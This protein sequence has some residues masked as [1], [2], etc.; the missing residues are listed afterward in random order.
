MASD[1]VLA[2]AI[3]RR[4]IDSGARGFSTEI[5]D[6]G[7]KKTALSAAK[8]ALATDPK[9][10]VKR[11]A[12][13]RA[14]KDLALSQKN[15][16]VRA[17]PFMPRNREGIRQIVQT[18]IQEGVHSAETG[19]AYLTLEDSWFKQIKEMGVGTKTTLDEGSGV[20]EVFSFTNKERPLVQWEG[21]ISD[22][23]QA[24]TGEFID[25]HIRIDQ[26]IFHD[27]E[28]FLVSVLADQ[29]FIQT[30]PETIPAAVLGVNNIDLST[31][32]N[33]DRATSTWK[34]KAKPDTKWVRVASGE[35]P[36]VENT[37]ISLRSA[38][39]PLIPLG[40]NMAGGPSDEIP[41]KITEAT[42]NY[43]LSRPKKERLNMM[44][45]ID[46]PNNIDHVPLSGAPAG[47]EGEYKLEF[48]DNGDIFISGNKSTPAPGGIGRNISPIERR[49]LKAYFN[50][51]LEEYK[52][53]LGV[54]ELNEAQRR[55]LHAEFAYIQRALGREILIGQQR[56]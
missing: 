21:D 33:Y 38:L 2:K 23:L 4:A 48:D 44:V 45:G 41:N 52:G 20:I 18:I 16:L 27:R 3:I 35:F 49:E 9:D 26:A 1:E 28:T 30:L 29:R 51:R 46:A 50:Q 14:Q 37:L 25:A 42:A 54:E 53:F 13:T 31:W 11:D 56:R 22:I 55:T 36:T 10:K 7:A 32:Y 15:L 19:N 43:Y 6:L 12:V 39:A 47:S 17:M 24:R 40:F 34:I 8:D 5:T